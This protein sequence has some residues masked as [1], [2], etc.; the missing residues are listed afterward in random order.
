MTSAQILRRISGYQLVSLVVLALAAAVFRP[1]ALVAVLAGGLLMAANFHLL[2]LLGRRAFSG[3][4]PKL[5]YALL[6][7][8]KLVVVLSLM[9]LFVLV[10]RLDPLAFAL[11]LGTL[12]VGLAIAILVPGGAA[13]ESQS[14]LPQMPG[15]AP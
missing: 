5:G 2:G 10:L 7:A 9:A 13:S 11:G 3:S 8:V 14:T 4:T 12:F 15:S 6:M 1:H